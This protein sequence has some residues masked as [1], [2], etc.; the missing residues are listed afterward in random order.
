[1]R[2]GLDVGGSKTEGVAVA[3]DGSIVARV[4]RATGWG[5]DA[6]VETILG[7][8]AD[9]GAE[10]GAE[11]SGA[12]PQIASVGIGIPGQ[13]APGSLW[14]E[15]A[16]NLGIE[17]L[18]VGDTVASTLGVQVYVD[19]DVRAAALGAAVLRGGSGSIGYLNLGTGIAAGIVTG[20]VT[21]SL[22]GSIAAAGSGRETVPAVWR[23]S[24]GA[25]GEVGHIS[26]DPAGPMCRCGQRGC[27]EALAGGAALAERWGRPGTHPVG[28]IFDAAESGDPLA[29]TLRGELARGVAAAVRIL[30]LTTDVET[31]VLGG[32]LTALGARLHDDVRRELEAVAEASVFLRSLALA[33]RV[34]LLPPGS[35]AAALG[36]ALSGAPEEGVLIHG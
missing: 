7:V 34:E 18:D 4:R 35:P 33:D 36:A 3:P 32:G 10:L 21:G 31:V 19:N 1:M 8:V 5:P 25:A 20:F 24:R 16:V 23:G 30:V 26:V 2:V 17:S 11:A 13:I 28:D 9:L 12:A 29:L 27:I 14:V 22:A 15:H 6:V